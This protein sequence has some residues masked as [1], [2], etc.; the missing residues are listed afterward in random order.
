VI[1]IYSSPTCGPCITLKAYFDRQGIEYEVLNR[2]EEPYTTQ[3]L[4]LCGDLYIPTTVIGDRVIRGLNIP[5]IKEALD[6]A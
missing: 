4:E 1:T 5:A 3:L 2:D 6:N